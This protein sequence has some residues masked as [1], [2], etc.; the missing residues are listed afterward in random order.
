MAYMAQRPAIA[1]AFSVREVVALGRHG[2]AGRRDAGPV[3]RGMERAGVSSLADAPIGELSVGQQQ[4]VG[5]ARALAQL[6]GPGEGKW[7]LADEPLSAL[8]PAHTR[9]CQGIFRALAR[10]GVG[11]GIVIHD[12]TTAVRTSDRTILLTGEG[13]VGGAGATREV[14]EPSLLAEVYA[15]PFVRSGEDVLPAT[16]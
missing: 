4:L 11:V 9:R 8:D 7:L 2:F 13:S 1:F 14:C 5:M 12:V 16:A 15:A 3:E 10:D 6:D